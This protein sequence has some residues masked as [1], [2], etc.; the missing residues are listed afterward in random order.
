[1]MMKWVH[2]YDLIKK[3]LL[4]RGWFAIGFNSGGSWKGG[5]RKRQKY[6]KSSEL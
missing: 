3:N 1:M 5:I 6:T 2:G 4:L